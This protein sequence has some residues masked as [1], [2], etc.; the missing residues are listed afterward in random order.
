MLGK[1]KCRR[2]FSLR[3]VI[4]VRGYV[5]SYSYAVSIF[6]DD[7]FSDIF[8][9]TGKNYMVDKVIETQNVRMK[10]VTVRHVANDTLQVS[11]NVQDNIIRS[12]ST[13]DVQEV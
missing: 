11:C 7:D 12:S 4:P 13:I 2:Y 1:T 9:V 5:P 3:D 10:D 8:S 6:D